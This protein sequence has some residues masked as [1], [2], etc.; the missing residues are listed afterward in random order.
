M[1]GSTNETNGL[2]VKSHGLTALLTFSFCITQR[3][4]F[5]SSLPET[6]GSAGMRGLPSPRRGLRRLV[7]FAGLI[8]LGPTIGTKLYSSW[9]EV[10]VSNAKRQLELERLDL[11]R[12]RLQE[13]DSS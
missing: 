5:I 3:E 1:C 13:R 2:K 12:K 8:F 11:E 7:L 6:C 9:N 10:S 4:T